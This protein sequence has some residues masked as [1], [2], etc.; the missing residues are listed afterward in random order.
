[1][2]VHSN[3][4]TLS[5]GAPWGLSLRL[6]TT[7]SVTV[8]FGIMVFGVLNYP[9]NALILLVAT[10]ILPAV[11]LLASALFLIRGYELS[12]D[13]LF[14]QRLGWKT[15]ID[16]QEL[17]AAEI[18]PEAM[19][20]SIRIFGNGGLF[21]FAGKFRNRKLGSFRVFATDPDLAVVLRFA[22]KIIVITPD[23]PHKFVAQIKRIQ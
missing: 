4:N 3:N 9:G 13:K 12:K 10:I 5:F 1:M 16:L 14:I 21:C 7:A 15:E 22:G 19:K 8:L 11:L 17:Q 18:D 2:K 23:E 6:I 20:K